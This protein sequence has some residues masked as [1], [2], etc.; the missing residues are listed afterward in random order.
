MNTTVDG[1]TIFT[2]LLDGGVTLRCSCGFIYRAPG[3][4][5]DNCPSC[6]RGQQHAEPATEAEYKASRRE[7]K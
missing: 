6:G 1:V 5:R 7:R 3:G 2:R 4:S